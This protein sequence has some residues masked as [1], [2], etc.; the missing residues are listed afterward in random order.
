MKNSSANILRPKPVPNPSA[1]AATLSQK[2]SNFLIK[3]SHFLTNLVTNNGLSQVDKAV[4]ELLY[5]YG[6]RIS[7]VLSIKAS[8][9]TF[10]GHI[11]LKT[12]KGSEPRFIQSILFPSF[13]VL[14]GKSILPLK[15]TYSRFYFYRLFKKLGYY[16]RYQGNQNF[17]VTH[18]FRHQLANDLKASGYSVSDVQAFLGHKS[19]KSTLHYYGRD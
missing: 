18:F 15:D 16:H 6:L 3:K 17:S 12:L 14:S 7:E 13:W 4:I 1:Q 19:E 2:K 10:M 9:V 11:K 8:D 5:F